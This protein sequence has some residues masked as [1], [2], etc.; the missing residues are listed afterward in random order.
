ML[1][2]LENSVV[3]IVTVVAAVLFMAM[4]DR[5]W[6]R[7]ARHPHNDVTGWQLSILGTTYAVILG[8]MLYA[9]WTNFGAATYNADLE[10]NNV[11][12]LFRLSDGLPEPQRTQIRTLTRSYATTVVER[13]WPEMAQ[14]QVPLESERINKQLWRVLMTLKEGT[15]AELLSRDHALTELDALTN[16]RRTRALQ[17]AERLPTVLWFVLIIG[18]I[19]S[20]VASTMF[21]SP[22]RFLHALQ[23]LSFSLLISLVLLAIADINRP[24]QG[25]V[26]VN[27]NAFRGAQE[28]IK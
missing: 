13:D 11:I 17:S 12:T 10:A 21:G 1:T 25:S 3:I 28:D 26:H 27:D 20:V 22:N 15:S 24:F 14:N 19:L 23:V 2:A 7:E 6:P 16:H 18:G 4:L 5:V 9:V 8:F